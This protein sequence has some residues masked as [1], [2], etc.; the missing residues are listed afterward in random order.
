MQA[1]VATAEMT[2]TGT[3]NTARPAADRPT[4][5]QEAVIDQLPSRPNSRVEQG[6]NP[7]GKKLSCTTRRLPGAGTP[8]VLF[9]SEPEDECGYQHEQ[10]R[11]TKSHR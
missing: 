6:R 2:A 9:A 4:A 8:R 11:N 10:A 3:K 7:G 5:L 1:P